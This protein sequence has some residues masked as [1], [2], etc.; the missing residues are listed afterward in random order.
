[1]RPRR[2]PLNTTTYQDFLATVRAYDRDAL[3]RALARASSE[4]DGSTH[5]SK[6]EIHP[7]LPWNVEGAAAVVISRGTRGKK[8]P[9]LEDVAWVCYL[10]SNLEHPGAPGEA[11]FALQLLARFLY[12]QMPYQRLSLKEWARTVALFAETE[13]K[14]H[15]HPK[16]MQPGWDQELLKGSIRDFVSIGFCLLAALSNGSFYPFIWGSGIKDVVDLL[17]GQDAFDAVVEH[18][19]LTDIDEFKRQRRAAVDD[20]VGSP[21]EKWKREPFAYNPLR[22]RPLVAGVVEA[23]WVAPCVPAVEL[24]TSSLGVIYSGLA[25]WQTDFTTDV[26]HLFEE[27][28]GRHL[29]LIPG[30][31]VSPEISYRVGRAIKLS[32]DWLVVLPDAVL[33]IECKSMIPSRAIREGLEDLADAHNRLSVAIGQVNRTAQ[34][35]VDRL[36]EF[37]LI[38]NDRPMIGLIVTLGTFDLAND[39]EIRSRLTDADIPT[40]IM[41]IEAMEDFVTLK[42]ADLA[43]VAQDVDASLIEG[44]NILDPK[45]WLAEAAFSPNPILET[46]FA[47]VPIIA[48]LAKRATSH[49]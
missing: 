13:F 33:L 14:L 19:F 7:F 30:G 6:G 8:T 4:W 16:V 3:L 29:A 48:R 10:F 26:G 1:M 24:R 9:T 27:Y 45:E 31:V 32:V 2:A 28:V 11:D 17:G 43:A 25:R 40:A 21:A 23:V 22:A 37:Q 46:A 38:P 20:L 49:P 47:S 18:N 39:F 36:P 12:Q 41:G 44:T 34:A 42:Q 5:N 35:V 15:H